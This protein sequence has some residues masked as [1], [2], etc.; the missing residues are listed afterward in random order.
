MAAAL[1]NRTFSEDLE[2][3]VGTNGSDG[4]VFVGMKLIRSTPISHNGSLL[5]N[6]VLAVGVLAAEGIFDDVGVYSSSGD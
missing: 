2:G 4:V 5:L 3:D 6:T 1:L